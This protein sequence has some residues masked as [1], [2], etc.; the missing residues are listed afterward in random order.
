[1]AKSG[2]PSP[3]TNPPS[4]SQQPRAASRPVTVAKDWLARPAIPES[5]PMLRKI[6]WGLAGLGLIVLIALSLGSGINADD[7]FQVDYSQKLVNYY[8]DLW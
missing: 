8:G 1:M 5:D 7:K 3:K 2:K 6:F 4:A